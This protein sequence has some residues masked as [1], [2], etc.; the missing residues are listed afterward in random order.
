[1]GKYNIQC[2]VKLHYKTHNHLYWV[3][4]IQSVSHLYLHA[5]QETEENDLSFLQVRKGRF[6]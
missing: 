1:M 3:N 2:K 5:I 6:G 4:S